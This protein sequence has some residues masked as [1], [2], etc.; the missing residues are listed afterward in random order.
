MA[1]ASHMGRGSSYPLCRG[2]GRGESRTW[3]LRG[4]PQLEA[5]EGDPTAPQPPKDGPSGT[6]PQALREGPEGLTVGGAGVARRSVG[7]T[8]HCIN[9]CVKH[10]LLSQNPCSTPSC[11]GL[12]V[13]GLE[14]GTQ[15]NHPIPGRR[16]GG[17]G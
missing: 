7:G 16:W 10:L 8:Y 2:V 6:D 13:A 17:L 3:G 9:K 5:E 4:S 15:T 11:T 14:V 12:V 1:F